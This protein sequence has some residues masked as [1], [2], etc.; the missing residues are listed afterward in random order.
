MGIDLYH[1]WDPFKGIFYDSKPTQAANH[2]WKQQPLESALLYK[3]TKK[4]KMWKLTASHWPQMD[5]NLTFIGSSVPKL[6]PSN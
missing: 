1:T 4:L 2:E 5:W 3:F 6:K